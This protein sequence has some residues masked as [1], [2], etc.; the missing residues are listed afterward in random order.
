MATDRQFGFIDI[1]QTIDNFHDTAIEHIDSELRGEF[2]EDVR[3]PFGITT[4]ND[5]HLD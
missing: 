2:L 3:Y 4:R 1:S 5:Q